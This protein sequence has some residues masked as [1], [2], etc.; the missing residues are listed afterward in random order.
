MTFLC[1]SPQP[2]DQIFASF[3]TQYSIYEIE[4]NLKALDIDVISFDEDLKHVIVSNRKG[5]ASNRLK[6]AGAQF[7]I[8]AKF[9]QFCSST[10]KTSELK[11]QL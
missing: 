8:K 10:P 7:V 1:L 6:K 2:N 3:N 5:D 9:A 4:N 11:S